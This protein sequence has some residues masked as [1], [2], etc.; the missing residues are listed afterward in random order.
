MGCCQFCDPNQPIAEDSRNGCQN[1]GQCVLQDLSG[2]GIPPNFQLPICDCQTGPVP[3][4]CRVD[5]LTFFGRPDLIP[6]RWAWVVAYVLV[7]LLSVLV[8]CQHV[9][10]AYNY[11][12]TNS[13]LA[14]FIGAL[15]IFGCAVASICSEAINP[16]GF[17]YGY[18][19]AYDVISYAISVNILLC[20]LTIAVAI[21]TGNWLWIGLAAVTPAFRGRDS[22]GWP[23]IA[24][25]TVVAVSEL[26]LGLYFSI[27]QPYYLLGTSLYLYISAGFLF[28]MLIFSVISGAFVLLTIS[29]IDT[30]DP[31]LLRNTAVQ[32]VIVCFFEL[33]AAIILV[34]IIALPADTYSS[35][36]EIFGVTTILPIL[37]QCI[38][39][40]LLLVQFRIAQ[41]QLK[42]VALT[43]HN[44][45]T[46]NQSSS[47]RNTAHSYNDE[48]AVSGSSY[49][50]DQKPLKKKESEDVVE[51]VIEL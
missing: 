35:G 22:W 2:E 29:E 13:N 41:W 37:V 24:L 47:A 10:Y 25:V 20:F 18:P 34:V 30:A 16:R 45:M 48:G 43:R 4:Q 40:T 6:V 14:K 32:L 3:P 27:Q 11:K 19:T 42:E 21:N 5:Y 46:G 49:V 50:E 31:K 1:F 15:L 38:F 44:T 26:V 9:Y 8:I 33:I 51:G 17:V 39:L 28:A 12:L 23:S 7:L 36:I